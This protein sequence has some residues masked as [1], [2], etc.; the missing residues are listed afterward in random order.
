MNEPSDV[1]AADVLCRPTA[2]TALALWCVNDH[3]LKYAY[4]GWLT[5]KLSDVASLIVAPLLAACLFDLAF[6]HATARMRRKLFLLALVAIGALM[7]SVK[8]FDSAAWAYRWGLGLLQ[9]PF[10]SLTGLLA[11]GSARPLRA[12]QLAMDWTDLLTLPALIVPWWL[13]AR[14]SSGDVCAQIVAGDDHVGVQAP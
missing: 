2:L 4:P 1:R 7:F 9:W 5:G 10:R 12:V 13:R 6:P 8:L 14:K 3:V 11:D